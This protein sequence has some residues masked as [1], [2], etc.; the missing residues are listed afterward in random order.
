M[1]THRQIAVI[2]P[3]QM[4]GAFSVLIHSAPNLD[5]LASAAD[6]D[7]LRTI[8]G[9]KK[10]DVF[11][12]YQVEES[13]SASGRSGYEVITRLKSIWPEGLC[14]AIVKYAQQ[15]ARVKEYGADLA[16]VDGVNAERLL[17]AI[18]GKIS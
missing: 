1:D 6:L 11:L 17:T 16:L 14:V 7:G 18:G 9:E 10:P 15:L 5:L 3:E 4:A 13:G 12:V 2:A 8:L